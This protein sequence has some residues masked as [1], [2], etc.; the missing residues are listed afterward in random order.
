ME[1]R[2]KDALRGLRASEPAHPL[3]STSWSYCSSESAI[4]VPEM[5]MKELSSEEVKKPEEKSEEKFEENKDVN[6]ITE[7]TK[8]LDSL[9]QFGDE[10]LTKREEFQFPGGSLKKKDR[11]ARNFSDA[12]LSAFTDLDFEMSW[13]EQF[14]AHGVKI[15][16]TKQGLME[17][18][19]VL[20]ITDQAEGES[21]AQNIFELFFKA[22][23]ASL[24]SRMVG[25]MQLGESWFLTDIS[26]K[27]TDK[28][29]REILYY[30][31]NFIIT[32]G[33]APTQFL[34]DTESRL[35]NI[36]GQ[37]FDVQQGDYTGQL[38]PLF[39]PKLLSTAP[40][41]KKTAWTDMQK[42][43]EQLKLL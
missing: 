41:M 17:N 33:A 24:F 11:I 15:L 27:T 32:L 42:V 16:K 26:D 43:M 4:S 22:H 28:I 37:F 25:A 13:S 14:S 36:H 8:M 40:N 2:Y 7:K 29:A 38:M 34:L 9:Y 6:L 5:D 31:P 19:D 20:F 3:F 12:T 23:V 1:N 30:Q 18:C 10:K 39:S 21:E 35:K